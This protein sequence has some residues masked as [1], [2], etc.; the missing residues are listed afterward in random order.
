MMKVML[1]CLDKSGIMYYAIDLANHL[2]YKDNKVI[3]LGYNSADEYLTKEIFCITTPQRSLGRILRSFLNTLFELKPDIIHFTGF[4]PFFLPLSLIAKMLDIPTV[5]TLHDA[6]RHP[7]TNQP[8]FKQ[9]CT[10]IVTGRFLVKMLISSVSEV[11]ALSNYVGDKIRATYIRKPYVIPLSQD[12]QRYKKYV[13]ISEEDIKT[14]INSTLN[15][16]FFGTIDKYKGIEY[17]LKACE[18]LIEKNVR[19]YLKIA[20]RA[21][22]YKLI[23]PSSISDYVII[24]NRFISESEIPYLF[25]N[26]DVVILPYIEV[27]QSGVLPLAFAFGKPVIATN[28]GSFPELVS[29]G[30]NG[31]L[32][33]PKSPGEIA[34]RIVEIYFDR[35]LLCN[36]SRNAQETYNLKLNWSKLVDDYIKLYKIL[37]TQKE[38]VL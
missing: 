16:L 29:N 37:I 17:L 34:E 28:I 24:E 9:L 36:L 20:G 21:Y 30:I 7:S 14:T 10:K 6:I 12:I 13:T 35:R 31:F 27:S 32:V 26:S 4:H 15:L 38:V 11:V 33:S 23:I 5:L 18:L 25:M 3:F 2:N 22:S 19:F 8:T 1:V